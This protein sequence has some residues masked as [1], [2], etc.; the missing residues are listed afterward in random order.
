MSL[1]PPRPERGALPDLRFRIL[2]LTAQPPL[3]RLLKRRAVSLGGRAKTPRKGV[4][5]LHVIGACSAQC[6][7]LLRIH[8][9]S[10]RCSALPTSNAVTSAKKRNRRVHF[11][12]QILR[13]RS[14]RCIGGR[15]GTAHM[16]PRKIPTEKI[17][18]L[19]REASHV[20]F[21]VSAHCR[22]ASL[23]L[24]SLSAGRQRGEILRAIEGQ[25]GRRTS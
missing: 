7:H 10:T 21:N 13:R 4:S 23:G 22:N 14:S 9:R 15:S 8:G 12:V 19:I 6:G 18:H 1:R 11:G 24:R 16:Q 25:H 3:A 20:A 17:P 5:V 2:P